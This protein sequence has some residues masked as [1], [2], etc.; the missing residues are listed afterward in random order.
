MEEAI[1]RGED[2]FQKGDAVTAL[3]VFEEVLERDPK[4]LRAQNDRGVALHS[5]GKDRE[6]ERVFLQ[7][8]ER[9]PENRDA[10]FNLAAL[11]RSCGRGRAAQRF[12]E[13][14]GERLS[15]EERATLLSTLGVPESAHEDGPDRKAVPFAGRLAWACIEE[16]LQK[17]LF[18]IVGCP[19]SGTTWVQNTLNGHPDI[20]CGGESNIKL[21][22]RLLGQLRIAYNQD[23]STI[24]K[25]Y[26]GQEGGFALFRERD[27]DVLFLSAVG[28]LFN[29]LAE[30]SHA[31]CLGFKNPDQLD[32][33]EITSSLYPNMKYLHIIRDGRDVTVSGWFHNLRT[34]EESFRRLFP[35]FRH[36]AESCAQA[37]D[38]KIRKA[39]AFGRENPRRYL[40]FRYED[41]HQEPEV[42]L[43]RILSFLEVDASPESVARCLEAGSF[44]RVSKGRN[45]GEE[46]RGSF[47]RK[48]IVGDWRNHFDEAGL[49]VFMRHAGSLLRDL[50]YA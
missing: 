23:I 24:N 6:A 19:K 38:Q 9:H 29:N 48:G 34:E 36:Y 44:Q 14:H 2:F 37:W 12:L 4:N 8:L 5:L 15:G 40:E 43:G 20:F 11:Y 35:G 32:C 25:T 27:L 39:R 7:L 18:L 49:R 26:I 50:G 47:F 28:L 21:L 45:R 31:A 30:Q 16:L 33:M 10:I 42:A 1:Q 46:D 13:R 41:L 22:G 17:K 3:K